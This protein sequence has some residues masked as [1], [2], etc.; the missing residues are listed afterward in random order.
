MIDPFGRCLTYLRLSVTDRCDLRCTYCMDESPDFL[1]RPEILSLEELDRLARA[2]VRKGV[3]KIRLTGG[4]PLTRR[5][6]MV[7]VRS[8]GGLVHSGDLDEVTLTT[9]GT[10]LARVAGELVEAG[11]RRVNVSLDTLDPA[12]FSAITRLGS[13]EKVL[14]GIAAAKKAGLD[15]KINMVVQQAVNDHE[16]DAMVAWC[17]FHGFDL[18]FIEPMPMGT[19]HQTGVPFDELLNRLCRRWTL[20]P[21]EHA[22][23]GPARYVMVAETGR[24]IGFIS[25]LSHGFC[26]SCNRLRVTC[27]GQLYMCLGAAGFVDLRAPLRASEGDALVEQA[28]DGA[29][30]RRPEGH[31]FAL[32]AAR[33]EGSG[34][35]MSLTGG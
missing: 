27:S 14:G 15:V 28:I 7:L 25:P 34:R 2:F 20:S 23:G 10:Q 12:R 22:T 9:N 21:S 3:R 1:P 6:V 16:I 33:K 8:L 13:L 26:G 11:V 4:E 19:G 18:C 30:A 35:A 17:G 29:V 32:L 31:S 24:R 5:N